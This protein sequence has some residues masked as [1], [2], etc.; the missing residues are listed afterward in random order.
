MAND[1]SAGG[2]VKNGP[3]SQ[4]A[5]RTMKIPN[6]M[7]KRMFLK[8]LMF[9]IFLNCNFLFSQTPVFKNCKDSICNAV[10]YQNFADS[11][12]GLMFLEKGHYFNDS[13]YLEYE[14]SDNGKVSVKQ[15]FSLNS[16]IAQAFYVKA[17]ESSGYLFSD[18]NWN[19]KF[20]TSFLLKLPKDTSHF[21]DI[22]KSAKPLPVS[23]CKGL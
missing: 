6:Q 21:V 11:L 14:F 2:R 4:Y 7:K 22:E 23:Y 1:K 16:D 5:N 20:G 8:I 10:A 15:G 13:I 12:A 9:G 3:M 17:I 19:Q 18:T